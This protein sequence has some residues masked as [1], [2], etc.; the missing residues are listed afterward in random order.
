MRSDSRFLAAGIQL[1]SA[2]KLHKGNH[3]MV[4][5]SALFQLFEHLALPSHPRFLGC[6]ENTKAKRYGICQENIRSLLKLLA[7]WLVFFFLL[8]MSRKGSNF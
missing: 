2:R 7:Q 6:N 8:K 1:H 4:L 5:F 3:M